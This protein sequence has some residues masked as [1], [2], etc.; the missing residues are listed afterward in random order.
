MFHSWY[1]FTVI[2]LTMVNLSMK[3]LWNGVVLEYVEP[4]LIIKSCSV[5]NF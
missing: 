3:S 4:F 1:K 5:V 2:V